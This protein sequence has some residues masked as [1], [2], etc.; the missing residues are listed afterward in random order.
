MLSS[1]YDLW[2]LTSP[3]V[4]FETGHLL[5]IA[6]KFLWSLVFDIARWAAELIIFVVNCFQVF[7]IFGLWHLRPKYYYMNRVV[8]CF[9]VFMIF[10]LWYP[11]LFL[12]C[13][14]RCCE[15]LSS[16]YDLWS[17]TSLLGAEQQS[18]KL[19][20]AFKFLWSL[21]FDI[22][23]KPRQPNLRVV[24]CFQVFMIFGLWHQSSIGAFF[25]P[26]VNCFQVFMIFGLWHRAGV[27]AGLGDCCE[28][29]SSF[30]DLWSLTSVYFFSLKM[31][32]LW[33]AFKF[34]WSLVFDISIRPKPQQQ[35][36]TGCH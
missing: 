23:N 22:P 17:L 11:L 1:F 10:G 31:I 6:F 5:W 28:L 4:P 20:I 35:R 8:N 18:C 32:K 25:C 16:F 19:W 21:V 14:G 26:V 30:Y 12:Q 15:L 9:Q 24:N 29:L 34:L 27:L 7:M 13:L 2:S 36:I 3:L 33:I